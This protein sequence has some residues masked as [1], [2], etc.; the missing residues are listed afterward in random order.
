MN[1]VSHFFDTEPAIPSGRGGYRPRAGAKKGNQNAKGRGNN[2]PKTTAEHDEDGQPMSAYARYEHARAE[3]ELHMA[4]QAAVKADLDEKAVVY[5]Q[6]V[7]DAAAQAFAACS[8]SLDA[9]ADMLE[10]EGM[11]LEVTQRVAELVNAAKSQLSAE[12]EKMYD[13]AGE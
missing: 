4:R 6:Q 3:K 8:Q 7:A 10:R 11:P 12:L 9:I 2:A 1:D 5:V 13:D